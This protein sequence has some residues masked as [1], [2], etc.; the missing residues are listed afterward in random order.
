MGCWDG[1][2]SPSQEKSSQKPKATVL[3]ASQPQRSLF[4]FL[5]V[6]IA[7][8][9]LSPSLTLSPLTARRLVITAS[10]APVH[11]TLLDM[12]SLETEVAADGGSGTAPTAADA[13]AEAPPAPSDEA[14]AAVPAATPVERGRF[15][16]HLHDRDE[17]SDD[18]DASKEEEDAV[19]GGDDDDDGS[20][21]ADSP[22]SFDTDEVFDDVEQQEGEPIIDADSDLERLLGPLPRRA[23][24]GENVQSL[25]VESDGSDGSRRKRAKRPGLCPCCPKAVRRGPCRLLASVTGGDG[26]PQIRVGNMIMVF[27][28][29]FQKKG[30]G[31]IGPH[32]CVKISSRR[33]SFCA[34]MNMLSGLDHKMH[35]SIFSPHGNY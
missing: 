31:I 6:A 27:P 17:D 4:L 26:L 22:K 2:P 28:K 12:T 14:I 33:D 1:V 3:C 5:S 24:G 25:E 11:R 23:S 18:D 34:E 19:G 9:H 30:F 15:V 16:L 13:E 35:F 8:S 32:W 21:S 10:A 20:A 7:I 29:C